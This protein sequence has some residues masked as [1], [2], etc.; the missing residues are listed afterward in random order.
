LVK[1]LFDLIRAGGA[2]CCKVRVAKLGW[3]DLVF[4]GEETIRGSRGSTQYSQG[5]L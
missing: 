5:A 1:G 4:K 2:F 3:L